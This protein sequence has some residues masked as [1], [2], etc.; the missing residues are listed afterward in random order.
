M[1]RSTGII[2][3][4]HGG[5]QD[6]VDRHLPLWEAF[7][8]PIYFVTPQNS[9][10]KTTHH[11]ITFGLSAHHGRMCFGRVMFILER[12]R[13]LPHTHF[14]FFEADSFGLDP[15]PILHKG[16]RANIAVN[17]EPGRFLAQR[18]INWPWTADRES[19]EKMLAVADKY[20]IYEEGYADRIYGALAQY[21]GIPILPHDPPG[22][23]PNDI[24]PEHWGIVW[25]LIRAGGV[26][27]HGIKDQATLDFM[28]NERKKF[29]ER[30]HPTL[31]SH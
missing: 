27:F 15:K 20:D 19:V 14:I 22:Y 31:A 18:Y 4:A 21:A 30:A 17:F 2:I 25:G 23:G 16:I 12:A 5:R 9:S 10:I 8:F 24:L 3:H 1:I 28:L 29:C 6:I 26:W 11:Q 7:G 13:D